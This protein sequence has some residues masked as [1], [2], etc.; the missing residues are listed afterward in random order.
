MRMRAFDVYEP[1]CVLMLGSAVGAQRL[2]WTAFLR[3]WCGGLK[4][5]QRAR[6]KGHL[7]GV[8][9]VAFDRFERRCRVERDCIGREVLVIG[10]RACL[11]YLWQDETDRCDAHVLRDLF[12]DWHD[13]AREAAYAAHQLWRRMGGELEVLVL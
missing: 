3:D 1:R 12:G 7:Q 4:G 8:H 2:T 10:P 13:T 9:H 6:Q 5:Y 11:L